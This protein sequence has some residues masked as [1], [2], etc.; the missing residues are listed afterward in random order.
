[1]LSIYLKKLNHIN[2]FPLFIKMWLGYYWKCHFL[3]CELICLIVMYKF[4]VSNFTQKKSI[5]NNEW[6]FLWKYFYYFC[7]R[8]VHLPLQSII[9]PSALFPSPGDGK[10]LSR[11][12]IL[13]LIPARAISIQT[14]S[15]RHLGTLFLHRTTESIIKTFHDLKR[16]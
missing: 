12:N 7:S 3:L 1:M 9:S 6:I 8:L 4:I 11:P 13:F 15:N 5:K 14:A 10:S 16:K 2:M